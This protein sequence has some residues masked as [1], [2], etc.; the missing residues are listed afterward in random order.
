MPEQGIINKVTLPPVDLIMDERTSIEGWR[1]FDRQN[2]KPENKELGLPFALITASLT[3]DLYCILYSSSSRKYCASP[4]KEKK[5]GRDDK[6]LHCI[7]LSI[8][9]SNVLLQ[10]KG[11]SNIV[12]SNR[13]PRG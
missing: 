11:H 8:L 3:S 2:V 4:A 5:S 7:P 13:S 1:Y 9:G 6:D 12:N 10:N